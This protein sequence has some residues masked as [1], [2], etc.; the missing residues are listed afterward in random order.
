[1]ARP[2]GV[3]GEAG[4]TGAEIISKREA[5]GIPGREQ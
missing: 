4:G 5:R 2:F 3:A 1:M